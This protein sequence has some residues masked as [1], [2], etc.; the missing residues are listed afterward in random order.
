MLKKKGKINPKEVLKER[1]F[2]D[3]VYSD[4][5]K[6][7]VPDF[8]VGKEL[9]I[10][11]EYLKLPAYITDTTSKDLGEYLNAYTQQKVYLRTVLGYAEVAAEE[12]RL[13]YTEASALEY[14]N[15]M[16]TKLSETAK[17]REVNSLDDVKP[18][19]DEW[20]ECK[21]RVK[22]ISYTISSIEDIIFML[23]REVSRRNGDFNEEN[24][25]YNVSRR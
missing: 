15:L 5:I 2:S 22:V 4:L 13:A 1:K 16:S 11:N 21:S 20:L 10:N 8:S 18:K 6:K 25:N 12:A 17:E 7:E 23:S 9:H 3:K 24:R 14:H 19:Y